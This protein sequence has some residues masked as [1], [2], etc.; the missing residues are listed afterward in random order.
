MPVKT[1]AVE[2]VTAEKGTSI[3][4]LAKTMDEEEVG[5]VVI[6]EGE[7][8]VGIVTDR[9]VALAFGRGEDLTSMTAEDLM[10]EGE[11][12]TVSADAEAD[13]LPK[14]LEEARVRRL[15]VVDDD[16]KLVGIVTLDDVVA[17]IG[18]ELDDVASV[19]ESQSR[20]YEASP[21]A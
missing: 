4:D 20:K 18:E 8:P 11:V 19:I 17:T 10:P 13:Q 15:P 12:R 7:R 9:D 6:V 14:R 21:D 5:D 3:E 16:G 2:A 1:I